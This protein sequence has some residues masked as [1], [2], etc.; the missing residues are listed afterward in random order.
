[1]ISVTRYKAHSSP[2]ALA[3]QHQQHQHL[4]LQ[5]PGGDQLGRDTDWPDLPTQHSQLPSTLLSPVTTDN[6][7]TPHIEIYFFIFYSITHILLF[8]FYVIYERLRGTI[9]GVVR[10]QPGSINGYYSACDR[11]ISYFSLWCQM[12]LFTFHILSP[13]LE[14]I[15]QRKIQFELRVCPPIQCSFLLHLQKR[16]SG[17]GII[18]RE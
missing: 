6:I 17:S 7:L 8:M 14:N 9:R 16:E 15:L 2:L 11:S 3:Q 1:M 13:I 4:S 10:Q 5:P 18:A 12:I